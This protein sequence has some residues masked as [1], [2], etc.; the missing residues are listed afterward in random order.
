[1]AK[2]D[3]YRHKE[4]YLAW[5]EKIQSQ[6]PEISKE[7]SDLTLRFLNDMEAGLNICS[8]SKKGARSYI[9]LNVLKQ[10]LIALSKTFEKRFNLTKITDIKNLIGNKKPT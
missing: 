1:M 5:K 4:R 7:N 8:S 10:R 6:I 3:P 2:I 9:R